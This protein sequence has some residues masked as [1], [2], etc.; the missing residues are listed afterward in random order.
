MDEEQIE[1]FRKEYHDLAKRVVARQQKEPISI[2]EA[3]R[4]TAIINGMLP[5]DE[6]SEPNKQEDDAKE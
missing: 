3:R 4:Q 1:Q 2:E 6:V 5:P